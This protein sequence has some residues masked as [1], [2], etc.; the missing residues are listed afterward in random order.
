VANFCANLA[1]CKF[2]RAGD[3]NLLKILLDWTMRIARFILLLMHSIIS[4]LGGMG[5]RNEFD[6]LSFEMERH[7]LLRYIA[8]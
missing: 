4:Q 2:M 5:L 7:E 8:R 1:L 6:L 3:E